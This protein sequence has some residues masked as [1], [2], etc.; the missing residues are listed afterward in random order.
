MKKVTSI[1]TRITIWYTALM[2]VLISI[3][4]VIIGTFSYRLSMERIETNLQ[5]QVNEIAQR[6]G[7]R[8]SE[9]IFYSIESKKEFR[10]VSIYSDKGEYIVGQYL[11][12]LADIPFDEF[13]PRKETV[14]GK[15][16]IVYDV[17]KPARPG[18]KGGYWI[19]GAEPVGMSK[20]FSRSFFIIILFI[21]PIILLLTAL[22][23]YYITRKAFSPINEIIR[24]AND[25]STKQNISKRI[26][27]NPE[28][29]KDELY[30]LSVTL[31]QMLDKIEDL[32]K[33][34]Q[35]FTSDAS[36]EL[37]T[38]IS[39]ILAQGEYLAEIAD[40]D[41]EKELAESIVLKA[42][43]VSELVSHLLLL[44]RI[45]ANRQK[46]KKEKVDLGVLIEIAVDNMQSFA[47]QKQILIFTNI[48]DDI[49]ISADEPLLLSAITNLISNAIKYGNENGRVVISAYKA[50]DTAELVIA[51]DGIGISEDNIDKIWDRFYR[52]DDVRNDEYGSS[53]LGLSMV[54]S[55]I[56]LH[57]GKI[58]VK[59]AM[60]KGTEFRVLLP[61]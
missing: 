40:T 37:R 23:G 49:F 60:N 39:V 50:N 21:T 20:I 33:Q 1:K 4:L 55:I 43:Q 38:P 19:R 36:H 48:D 54:K 10:N 7:G 26:Q 5:K 18:E 15:E 3:L 47:S 57:G 41:K 61:M 30:H 25:I 42:K 8:H 45:D 31:N 12:D 59:S 13:F 16:Y 51:D 14:E 9:E 28:M 35:Q 46:L 6:V 58:E 52:T 32:I 2:L 29:K 53:G 56:T 17:F 34:E 27:I 44:A 24:T 11:Y 22:G